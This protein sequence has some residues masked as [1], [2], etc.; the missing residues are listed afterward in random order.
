[1]NSSASHKSSL[2][3]RESAPS[4]VVIGIAA[5]TYFFGALGIYAFDP[6]FLPLA[7]GMGGG[8]VVSVYL[9]LEGKGSLLNPYTLFFASV[10]AGCVAGYFITK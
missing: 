1:M 6:V 4:P 10:V 5:F 3:R 9:T 7:W 2:L 8:L